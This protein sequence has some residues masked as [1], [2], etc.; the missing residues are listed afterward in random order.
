MTA[1][2]ASRTGFAGI[3]SLALAT[4]AACGVADE[5]ATTGESPKVS[6]ATPRDAL[7]T[8]VP[9]TKVGAYKFDIKGGVTPM[10]GVLDAP[11]KTI[12]LKVVQQEPDVDLTMTMRW[13]VIDDKGWMRVA[14]AP[15]NL[16]GLP[17]LPKKWVL[18]DPAKVKDPDNSPLEYGDETDPGYVTQLV[19]NSADLTETS[20]GHFAGTTDLTQVTDAE[21]V[22][23]KTLKALGDKAKAVPFTAVIDGAG[24]LTSAVVKVPAAGKAKAATYQVAY[25]G[26]GKT[27]TPTAPAANEQTPATAAV[28]EL[29]NG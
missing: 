12:E 29:L 20:P 14:F 15:A 25:T 13:L 3:L 7:L 11:K 5:P 21:I 19:Q 26:F 8:A 24:H 16:P 23:E 6:V 28:Y 18:L 10:S 1:R 27:A 22:D 9:D 2:M 17:K 4:S